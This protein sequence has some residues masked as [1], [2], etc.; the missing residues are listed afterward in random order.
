MET[1]KRSIEQEMTSSLKKFLKDRGHYASG[2]LYKSIKVKV[3]QNIQIKINAYE[4]LV[5]LEDGD[6]I[7]DFFNLASTK[8]SIVDLGIIAANEALSS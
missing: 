8:Q 3:D 4:Y 1:T 7:K 2:K 6:F 5:Y